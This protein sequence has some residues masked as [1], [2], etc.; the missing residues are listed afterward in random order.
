MLKGTKAEVSPIHW[1]YGG[2]ARLKADDVID[3]LLYGGYST[4]TLGYVGM[5]EMCYAKRSLWKFLKSYKGDKII[6]LTTHSLM[7]PNI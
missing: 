5:C 6:I 2:L 1:M 3:P 4:I 7:K